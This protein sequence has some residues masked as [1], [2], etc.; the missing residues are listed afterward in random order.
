MATKTS[1]IGIIDSGIGGFSVTLK[2][3][4]RLPHENLLYFGDGGNMP[5]GNHPAEE[6]LT[7]TR[8]MLR[9]MEERGVKALLVACSTISCLID[10]Y[11]EDM[12]CPVLSVVQAGVDVVAQ[13]P[14]R[15][16]GVISTCFTH[17]TR[18]YPELIG[19]AA[20]DKTVLS[21][22]C[23]DLANLIERNVG[24]P[25]GQAAIDAALKGNLEEL[26]CKENIDCC[27]LGC[28]H[29]PLVEPNIRRLYPGLELVDP[30]DYMAGTVCRYLQAEGLANDQAEQGRLDIYTTGNVEEYREKAEK[31]GLNPVTSV[32]AYPAMKLESSA[33]G[34]IGL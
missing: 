28:T 18:C 3:Q 10:Q 15:K 29:Y 22:G 23:P 25:E 32:Q 6:I 20:P 33:L 4:Q 7:M 17:E 14:A 5:Y 1:P 30:A 16:V 34:R 12:S 21:H 2:M 26:V 27:V 19:K 9:F 24:H 31:V 13:M 8:Y 11:R